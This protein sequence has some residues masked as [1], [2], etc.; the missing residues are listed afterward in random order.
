MIVEIACNN[1][2]SCKNAQDAGANRIE[3]IE[4]LGEGGCTPSFGMIKKV[5]EKISI[6]IYV[7]IR[8][9]GGDF[10]YSN[11]EIEIMHEDIRMCKQLNVDGIVFGVLTKEGNVNLE[12]CADLLQTWGSNKATFH[13]ALD[14]TVDI[15]TSLEDIVN[16]G[17]ER[18]LTSGGHKNVTEGKEVIKSLQE[19]L[20]SQISIMPGAG[21][22]PANGKEIAEYCG[23]NEI[24]ATCKMPFKQNVSGNVNFSDG[25]PLSDKKLITDLVGAFN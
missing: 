6:P 10:V 8:P 14:R 4:N 17:F 20:G 5:K 12:V 11:D 24:H 9:R 23:T 1:F 19:K 25:F 15:E 2:I 13:R 7:M 16:L 18:V 21:V 22:T 3:L